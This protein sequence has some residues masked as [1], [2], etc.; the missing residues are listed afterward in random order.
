VSE[1]EKK[2]E[3]PGADADWAVLD[4]DEVRALPHALGARQRIT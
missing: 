1:R 2:E 3:V 4:A